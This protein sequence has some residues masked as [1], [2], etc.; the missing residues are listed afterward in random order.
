M[1]INAEGAESTH[2]LDAAKKRC[3]YCGGT[4]FMISTTL[5]NFNDITGSDGADLS[6][7]NAGAQDIQAEVLLCKQCGHED[8]GLWYIIDVG[9]ATAAAITMTNLVATVANGLAGCYAIPLAGTD[10]GKYYIISSNTAADPTVITVSVATNGD[11]DG[12]YIITN[13]LPVGLTAA[14]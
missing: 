7:T 1:T 5:D 12:Y 13:R 6:L 2:V 3:N 8:T 11:E 10:V 9:A 4:Q 14:S